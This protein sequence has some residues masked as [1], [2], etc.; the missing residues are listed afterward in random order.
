MRIN[1]V[2][3]RVATGEGDFGFFVKFGKKLTIIRG[4]NSSGKS[5]LFLCLLYALGME[6]IAGGKNEAILP[7]A[8]KDHFMYDGR[9]IE[10]L[11]SEVYLEVTNGSGEVLTFRRAIRDPQKSSKLIEV[12][13]GTWL[14]DRPHTSRIRPTYLHDAGGAQ[15]A[16]GFHNLLEKFLGYE[17]P[18][19]PTTSGGST[20]LY[21]QA[22]FAAIAVE[23]KRGWTDYIANIP[24][25]GIRDARTRV[26]EFLLDLD[27]FSTNAERNRLN[28]ESVVIA[29]AW[30][31]A[32]QALQSIS[33]DNSFDVAN[34]PSKVSALF[35]TSEI[36]VQK[37]DG[38]ELFPLHTYI[39]K[40]KSEHERIEQRTTTGPEPKSSEAESALDLGKKE[41]FRLANLYDTAV[42]TQAYQ[43]ASVK[44]YE[45]LYR[46]AADD[47]ARNRTALK[48]RKL[49]AEE[50]EVALASDRCPTCHQTVEDSLLTGL[51]EG[52]QMDLETNVL[53]LEKQARMLE[54]QIA[55]GR[56][57]AAESDALIH[58]LS[59]KMSETR[60]WLAALRSDVATDAVESRALIRRQ[61]QIETE[62]ERLQTVQT[63][64]AKLI[65]K[66]QM[67]A[68]QLQA[69]QS[70]RKMVPKEYYSDEDKR[71]I[72][73]FEKLFRANASSFEYESAE[74][75]D[76]HVNDET[77]VPFLQNIELRE[78][79]TDIKADSSASD[80]VRL[81]LSYL[82]AL[83]QASSLP[84]GGGRHPGILLFDEPGQHSMAQSS[85]RALLLQIVG[86]PL[87]QGIVAA[88][89]DES[90]EVFKE[91]TR[92]IEFELVELGA[93]SIQ[94][95]F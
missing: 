23:Q 80:F 52:P 55:G 18:S 84:G 81:I 78:I 21:L 7:Y 69:N 13:D 95:L 39:A 16:E 1:A 26:V 24:F 73:V 5:T 15:K 32:F 31:S 86:A 51:I 36:V 42:S 60:E 65:D 83:H 6:E 67:L 46:E 92:G 20:K 43:R 68:K 50:F 79:K 14:T 75:K 9:R 82:L 38:D 66:F 90:P 77:L 12:L 19:V 47:L 45:L 25:F 49:G 56:N 64:L 70:R 88:S 33:Q 40:L 93:K 3:L 28:A 2:K 87:L 44:E 53:Y 34:V 17:L 85:Q 30:D 59:R 4:N 71:K 8:T 63:E 11:A 61:V 54:R 57:A 41:L 62:I 89:F 48:L 10:V 27:V 35:L 94:P 29:T 22:I 76:I 91:V 74:V 72:R 58:D 37:R